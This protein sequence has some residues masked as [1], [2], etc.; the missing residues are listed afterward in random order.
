MRAIFKDERTRE[1]TQLQRERVYAAQF[2]ALGVDYDYPT[3]PLGSLVQPQQP[4]A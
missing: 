2:A 3:M 1:L 4:A